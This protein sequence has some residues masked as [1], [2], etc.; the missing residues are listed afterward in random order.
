MFAWAVGVAVAMGRPC[1]VACC[2]GCVVVAACGGAV[3]SGAV[4]RVLVRRVGRGSHGAIALDVVGAMVAC[5]CLL[6]RARVHALA[7]VS[8]SV[9]RACVDV[10]TLGRVA[11]ARCV[12]LE[13]AF[14][15]R[16]VCS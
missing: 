15:G 14:G 5:V 9:R 1:V 11:C 8:W 12:N 7:R 3:D 10:R 6:A 16:R 13:A 2:A 4:S